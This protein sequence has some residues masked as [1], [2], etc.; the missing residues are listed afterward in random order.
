MAFDKSLD[1]EIFGEDV[2]FDT[3]KIRVSVM[4]YNE[5]QKKL[6]IMQNYYWVQVPVHFC[7]SRWHDHID[8]V[9]G[10]NSLPWSSPPHGAW[11]SR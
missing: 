4:S 6:Q 1:K 7:N 8:D 5:G 3:T 10:T 2:V 11:S 9:G